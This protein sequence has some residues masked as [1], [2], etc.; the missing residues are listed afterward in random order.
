VALGKSN[1]FNTSVD[2]AV[3]PDCTLLSF[4]VVGWFARRF[5]R[6]A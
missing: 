6:E 4:R 5:K 1:A 3:H 2:T